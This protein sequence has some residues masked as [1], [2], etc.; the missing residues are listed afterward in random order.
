M[1]T[2]DRFSVTR[3]AFCNELRLTFPEL[4]PQIDRADTVTA[5][6]FWAMWN[7]D[8]PILLQRDVGNLFEKRRGLLLGAVQM[9]PALWGEL[10][11]TTQGVIWQY[12]RTM[13][14]EVVMTMNLDSM[15]TTIMQQ[16]SGIITEERLLSG[17]AEAD[18]EKTEMFDQLKPLMD[19]MKGM[20][21]GFM[22]MSGN[23]AGTF[24]ADFAGASFPEIPEKLKKGKIAKLAEEMAKEIDLTEFGLDP[25]MLKTDNIE[26]IA[27]ALY[28]IYKRDPG[29]LMSG[30]KRMADK[31]KAKL[32]GGSINRE[33]LLAEA[34]EFVA[35]FKDHPLF[36]EGIA[37]FEGLMGAGGMAEMFG[38]PSA[39]AP[40]ERRR[41]VQERLR[42]KLAERSQKK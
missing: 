42:K 39:A 24:A 33:E 36:K 41:A 17:G 38:S 27:K 9:T 15:D 4:T 10:S 20:L 11:E 19:R 8:M 30:A 32:A 29:V 21:G 35:L 28:E 12:L 6:Q 34:R 23:F 3:A 14:L 26:D 25:A 16:L 37:K 22:D 2:P 18:A 40:S 31:I 5:S 1:T 13:M 7:S